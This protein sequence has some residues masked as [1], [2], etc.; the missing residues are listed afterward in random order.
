MEKISASIRKTGIGLKS[1]VK[2]WLSASHAIT[3]PF[4]YGFVNDKA[5][6]KI[7][8]EPKLTPSKP[9]IYE[10]SK[11]CYGCTREITRRMKVH[12]V[13]LLNTEQNLCSTCNRYIARKI[14]KDAEINEL[15]NDSFLGKNSDVKSAQELISLYR[16]PI[17]LESSEWD[18]HILRH[19][20][21][22]DWESLKNESLNEINREAI[23]KSNTVSKRQTQKLNENR[24]KR[25]FFYT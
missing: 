24:P 11:Y 5:K 21:F 10:P 8:T 7:S 19:T 6:V 15:L 1:M 25:R 9:V 20:R 4:A 12:K 3:K 14:K 16:K 2:K 18:N 22:N 23:V 13:E 17:D